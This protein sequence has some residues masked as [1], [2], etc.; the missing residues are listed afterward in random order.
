MA[1]S[2]RQI[3]NRIRGI[4][5]VKK[6]THAMEMISIAKLRAIESKFSSLRQYF[7][8]IENLVKKVGSH[9]GILDHQLFQKATKKGTVAVCIITSDTGL[10]SSYNHNVMRS[11]ED[12]MRGFAQENVRVI[13]AGRKGFNHF[14]A[15]GYNVIHSFIELHGRFDETVSAVILQKVNDIFL[16]KAVDEVYLA[17]THFESASRHKVMIEK[18]LPMEFPSGPM[19]E[20]YIFEPEPE[21]LLDELIP[22]YVANKFNAVLLD[23]FLCEHSSRMVAMAEATNNAKDLLE[24]LTLQRN[25]LRQANIT[26]EIL[27]II[28]SAEVLR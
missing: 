6:V 8:V 19:D 17:Y 9:T 14:R 15:K 12:F 11:A 28:S 22:I 5:N 21:K 4:E 7:Q 18:W 26:K 2:L 20:A 24:G 16:S 27:E 25:K 1:L 10:C 3:K 23:A 13:T